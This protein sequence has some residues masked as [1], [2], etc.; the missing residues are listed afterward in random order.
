MRK[1][2][3]T[4]LNFIL[5]LLTSLFVLGNTTN[6]Q[7]S[8]LSDVINENM[9]QQQ[10]ST[11]GESVSQGNAQNNDI[12]NELQHANQYDDSVQSVDYINSLTSKAASVIVQVLGY[13][14][15]AFLAVRVVLDLCYIALPFTRS[16]LANGYS[17]T[18]PQSNNGG[19]QGPMGGMNG[20][21]GMSRMGGLSGPTGMMG[22]MGGAP[23]GMMPSM[24]GQMGAQQPAG[25]IQFVST[26]ALNAV[27]AEQNGEQHPLRMYAKDMIVILVFTVVLLILAVSGVLTNLGLLI[28]KAIAYRI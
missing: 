20:M 2:K 8:S 1:N 15:T 18:A 16:I 7:A 25:K 11:G 26:A 12:I 3:N 4:L 6:V 17:G 22:A 14:L 24:G 19:M 10:E 23:N 27:A 5:I 13:F 21:G 28:G 9:I